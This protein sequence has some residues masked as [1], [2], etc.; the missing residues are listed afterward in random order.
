MFNVFYR[1]LRLSRMV[2]TFYIFL[3]LATILV[4]ISIFFIIE[5]FRNDTNKYIEVKRTAYLNITSYGKT[6]NEIKQ[7]FK[8]LNKQLDGVRCDKVNGA[9]LANECIR[10]KADIK[11][12]MPLLDSTTRASNS[13]SLALDIIN[14]LK[15]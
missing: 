13:Q 4:L 12:V 7:A 11:E 5:P 3:A 14:I 1:L 2:L 15:S 10:L 9:N 6:E 8:D